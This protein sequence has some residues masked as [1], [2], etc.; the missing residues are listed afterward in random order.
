M[1]N[2]IKPT[3]KEAD[4]TLICFFTREWVLDRWLECLDKL[5]IDRANTELVLVIDV[6]NYAIYERLVSY[7]V[8]KQNEYGGVKVY[9]SDQWAVN[10]VRVYAR[11]DRICQIHAE[12]QDIIGNTRYVFGLEDDTIFPPD[13]FTKLQQINNTYP[14]VGYASG[15]QVG[16]W[17]IR[18]IGAW[19][20]ND[21]DNPTRMQ[22]IPYTE[23]ELVNVDGGGLYCF[24]TPTDLYKNATWHW[25]DECFGPDVCYGIDLRKRG[26]Q[27]VVDTSLE[28]GHLTEQGVLYPSE[29]SVVAEYN[30]L[31]DGDND[32]WKLKPIVGVKGH[33][34]N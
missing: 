18:Y 12:T 1:L 13:A 10:T 34:E 4:V 11:R 31:N 20:T 33:H 32:Y 25:H 23:N 28:C 21:L 8:A 29:Q 9:N 19:Q 2:L 27:C 26:Y 15:I 17:D 16:R 30:K 24:L 6:K 22:T 5:I 3:H 7:A 14:N